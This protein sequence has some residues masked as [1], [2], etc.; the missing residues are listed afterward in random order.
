MLIYRYQ[1]SLQIHTQS[2]FN[3]RMI[4]VHDKYTFCRFY[5]FDHYQCLKFEGISFAMLTEYK[6][7]NKRNGTVYHW[8]HSDILRYIYI[9]RLYLLHKFITLRNSFVKVVKRKYDWLS[10]VRSQIH[11]SQPASHIQRSTQYTWY[12]C[13]CMWVNDT[14]KSPKVLIAISLQKI[15]QNSKIS[16]TNARKNTETDTEIILSHNNYVWY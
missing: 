7:A 16:G 5:L 4:G 1:G 2:H 12:T 6:H 8:L 9:L 10:C 13:R 3:H 15:A 11:I 14:L